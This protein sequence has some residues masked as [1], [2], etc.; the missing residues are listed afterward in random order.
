M[1]AR[2]AAAWRQDPLQRIAVAQQQ[3]ERRDAAIVVA[4]AAARAE[5]PDGVVETKRL[6]RVLHGRA[7]ASPRVLD[8]LPGPRALSKMLPQVGYELLDGM[9]QAAALASLLLSA[10]RA[11][12]TAELR[13]SIRARDPSALRHLAGDVELSCWLREKNGDVGARRTRPARKPSGAA[14]SGVYRW[15]TARGFG[16]DGFAVCLDGLHDRR[17]RPI[18]YSH[19]LPRGTRQQIE[20]QTVYLQ[21]RVLAGC[22]SGGGERGGGCAAL[23]IVDC[24]KPS[25]RQPDAA[26]RKG[27]IDV[28]AAHYPWANRGTTVFVGVPRPLR[29]IF[30]VT[31]PFFPRELYERFRFVEHPRELVSEGYVARRQLPLARR[32]LRLERATYVLSALLTRGRDLQARTTRPGRDAMAPSPSSVKCTRYRSGGFRPTFTTFPG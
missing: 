24:K 3:L 6:D 30:K 29:Y 14:A 23:I 31:K 4:V 32:Q 13:S 10:A 7:V 27:G 16:A 21:E 26:L 22:T 28:V 15:R 20:R 17:G 9:L 5:R 12:S 1:L 18:V 11:S 25:F 2:V 19:G 8:A